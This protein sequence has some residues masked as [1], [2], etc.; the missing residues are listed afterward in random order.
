MLITIRL[1]PPRSRYISRHHQNKNYNGRD[2]KR[3]GHLAGKDVIPFDEAVAKIKAAADART[4]A[5]FVIQSRTD[6]FAVNGLDDVITRLN[7]FSEAG[8][9]FLFADGLTKAREKRIKLSIG[10]VAELSKCPNDVVSKIG[11]SVLCSQP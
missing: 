6:T 5:D 4:D 2:R 7:A 3:C 8:A 1:Q 10:R 9:D 11:K